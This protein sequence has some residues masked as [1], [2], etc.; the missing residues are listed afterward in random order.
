[1]K[2]VIISLLVLCLFPLMTYAKT[3]TQED[4][5]LEIAKIENVQVDD[6]VRILKTSVTDTTIELEL[7]L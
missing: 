6:N 3:N 7:I 2:K 5:L 4:L 1:M